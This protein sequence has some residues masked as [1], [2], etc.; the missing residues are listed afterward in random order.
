MLKVDIIKELPAFEINVS[1]ECRSGELLALV[2]PSGAGKTT[3]MRIVAG[4]EQADVGRITFNSETWL[5]TRGKT[6]LPPQ[7]RNL[8]YVF[9]EYTLFPHLT[10]F[11]NVAFAGTDKKKVVDLLKLLDVWHLRERKPRKLSGG[12]RQRVALAQ[13]L[14][15]DPKVLLLDEPFSALDIV[16]RRNLRQI[17][18][19]LKKEFNLPVIHITH[20]L[21][22]AECL[23][24]TLLPVVNGRIEKGWLAE[25]PGQNHRGSEPDRPGG[26]IIQLSSH[27]NFSSAAGK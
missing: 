10:V 26:E 6:F 3:L 5:E 8:G 27:V 11:R 22:E 2:G 7:K 19:V 16:T 21:E 17:L 25:R 9:Q 24:D 15:K 23:A 18:L 20:D 4:L 1:F 12:E 14:A 13:A